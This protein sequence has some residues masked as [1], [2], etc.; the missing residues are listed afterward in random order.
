MFIRMIGRFSLPLLAASL[1]VTSAC[2]DDDDDNPG[3]PDASENTPDA[4]P[5]SPDASTSTPDS[6][7]TPDSSGGNPDSGGTA[8]QVYC[9]EVA[10]NCTL[11]AEICCVTGIGGSATAECTA[12]ADCTGGQT[13][14]IFCDGPEDCDTGGG[15]VCCGSIGTSSTSCTSD[16]CYFT[17]C[18][19]PEDCPGENDQCC[20]TEYGGYCSGY[21]CY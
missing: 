10:G 13:A 16:T 9:G 7:P 19:S 20:A 15:E 1:L 8:G 21:G 12:E 4:A 3:T 14:K 11:P 18:G 6:A 17:I 5:G 2:G